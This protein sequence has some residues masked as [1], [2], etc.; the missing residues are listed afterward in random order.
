MAQHP[1]PHEHSE[2]C[3]VLDID[4]DTTIEEIYAQAMAAQARSILADI[5]AATTLLEALR[6]DLDETTPNQVRTISAALVLF[7]T[8]NTLQMSKELKRKQI[9]EMRD[10]AEKLLNIALEDEQDKGERA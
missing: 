9:K 6:I 2:N 1:H 8:T 10:A 3:V 7:A 5:P 4:A